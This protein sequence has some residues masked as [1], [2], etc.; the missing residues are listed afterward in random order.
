MTAS[1]HDT[2]LS[3]ESRPMRQPG[4][5][6]VTGIPGWL[7]AAVLRS[8]AD[9]PPAGL[10]RVRCLVAPAMAC[11][12][13]ALRRDHGG[14]DLELVRADLR[15]GAALTR[16]VAGM[17]SVLHGAAILHVRRPREWYDINTTGTRLLAEAAAAAG[18]T[19]FVHISSNAAG[20]RSHAR[21]HLL[22]E[23]QPARPMSHYGRSKHQ[24]ELAVNALSGRMET[25]NLRPCMFYGPPVPARHIDVYRRIM[26]GRMPLVGG[27]DFAR[28]VVHID[29]LIQCCRLALGHPAA[30]GQTYYVADRQVHTTRS[31]VEA[32][33]RALGVPPRFLP[34]PR[35]VAPV[36]YLG[37]MALAACGLYWQTLHLV[38][39]ADWHVGVSIAK[40][41]RE[42]GYA[43]AVAL[44]EG[45]A[46]A[47]AWCRDHGHLPRL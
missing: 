13:A 16:A 18:V 2:G 20:G 7:G 4:N 19:R 38:G 10:V 40:A 21:D 11:D 36:A 12:E 29:N 27:G 26:A 15:D 24:A 1:D 14:L 22:T 41:E 33:A 45:L 17:D 34:L 6:L 9:R 32:M 28:S 39:E 37:D 5:L 31:V 35:L 30:A 25:V 42:L 8:L 23:D 44:D 47:I 46:Q 43:P 3:E